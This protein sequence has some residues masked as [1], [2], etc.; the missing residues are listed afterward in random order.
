[1]TDP[2]N[3]ERFFDDYAELYD[4]IYADHDFRDAEFYVDR[5]CEADGPVLEVACGTGRVYLDLLDAGVDADG[6]DLSRGMLDELERKA[7]ERG[8]DP[9][10]WKADMREFDP[11]REYALVIVPFRSFLHNV[12]AADQ[13]R[14][15]ERFREALAPDGELVINTFAPNFDE[16]CGEYGETRESFV[17]V[18]DLA[19]QEERT[20]EFDDEVEQVVSFQWLFTPVGPAEEFETDRQVEADLP[21]EVPAL[22]INEFKLSLI[23]KQQFELLFARA[24]YSEYELH[25]GFDLDPYES[26]EQEMVWI[27][28]P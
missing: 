15:L 18:D 11:P 8:L 21:E 26:P 22:L 9:E 5:A 19:F 16:I 27:A 25:A 13:V 12:T 28:S 24:G 17:A 6:F 23:P 2:S 7:D 1:M 20:S 14:A 10:V 4:V 3:A